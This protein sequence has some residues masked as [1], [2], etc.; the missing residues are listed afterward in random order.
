MAFL[1]LAG[2]TGFWLGQKSAGLFFPG[3][4][5]GSN[6]SLL[7]KGNEVNLDLFWDV[8]NRLENSF[9]DQSKLD[10]EKMIYGAI[11]GMVA[12]LGDPYTSFLPPEENQRSLQDLAGSFGGVGIQLGFLE[13]GLAVIA[14]L[15]QTPAEEA[16]IKAGDLILKIDDQE[17]LAM[18]L[19]QAV[20]L[21]RGE[22]GT[23][24]SLILKRESIKEPFEVKVTRGEILVKSVEVDFLNDWCGQSKCPLVTHLKLIRFGDR[25]NEEW[26]EAVALI[27]KK[28]P[29][30]SSDCRG[31]ILDL[32]N[33]P[34]GYLA[35]SVF[36]ASEFLPSGT[37]AQEE[38]S[39][40]RRQPFLVNRQ[41]SLLKH[42]LVVL[43]DQGSASASE[44]VAGALK[45]NQRAAVIGEAT[46]G[47]GSI[48]DLQDLRGG[49]G[50]YITTNRWLL[51]GGQSVENQGLEPD[52][53][54]ENDPDRPEEDNQLQK[55]IE[56]LS[57]L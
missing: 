10:S 19:P 13:S 8:W 51:P 52:Y 27:K 11:E 35:S 50:L 24:V 47:K 14:P 29:V 31:I 9:I 39:S 28:C 6:L 33:N 48:Q 40:G 1:F 36:I 25:T 7:K 41:G 44:I 32:R 16:G 4:Q 2:W 43:V 15:S 42:S 46:F 30:E 3:S 22:E 21:I 12:S 34:G 38:D 17:T 55:A 37:V 53:L 57:S 26:S 56:I 5:S 23:Q 20:N 45:E 18:S 54:V 49:G